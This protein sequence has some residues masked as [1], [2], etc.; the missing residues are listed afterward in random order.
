MN[1]VTDG[2]SVG[3]L[4]QIINLIFTYFLPKKRYYSCNRVI[5]VIV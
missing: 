4:R 2:V 3:M 1:D 5:C